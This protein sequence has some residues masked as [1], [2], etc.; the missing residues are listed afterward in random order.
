MHRKWLRA[1]PLTSVS[2]CTECRENGTKNTQNALV[3]SRLCIFLPGGSSHSPIPAQ[4]P[5]G[6][7]SGTLPLWQGLAPQPELPILLH[8]GEPRRHET[9]SAPREHLLLAPVRGPMCVVSIG[10]MLVPCDSSL[11][12]DPPSLPLWCELS[13]CLWC[14]VC[15]ICGVLTLYQHRTLSVWPPDHL[16]AMCVWPDWSKASRAHWPEGVAVPRETPG[17]S[18]RHATSGIGRAEKKGRASQLQ[19]V[20]YTQAVLRLPHQVTGANTGLSLRLWMLQKRQFFPHSLLCS[21]VELCSLKN[22]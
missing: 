17:L 1:F 10:H 20:P 4:P 6:R 22:N 8:E 3:I 2:V 12:W 11:R 15:V 13:L 16:P 19:H 18:G 9:H 5:S 7:P 14:G 21:Y